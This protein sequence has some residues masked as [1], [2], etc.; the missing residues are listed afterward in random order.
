MEQVREELLRDDFPYRVVL[1]SDIGCR[2][3][4]QDRAFF[5]ALHEELFAVV[6]DGMGGTD[7]GALASETAICVAEKLFAQRIESGRTEE[8]AAF[9]QNVLFETDDTVYD[10]LGRKD[11]GTTELAVLVQRDQLFWFSVGDSRL[12][13]FRDGDMIQATRDHNYMLR[14]DEQMEKKEIT[15]EFYRSEEERGEALISYMGMGGVTTF[16]LTHTPFE[17]KAGD[18]LLLCTDGLYKALPQEMIRYVLSTNSTLDRKARQL[19][20]QVLVQKEMLLLDNTTF[21]LIEL[22]E[23]GGKN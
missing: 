1:R 7:C 18:I 11:G 8:V 15:E 6:C 14:L 4:Q 5:K 21:V 20:S 9:L 19:M 16:D 23:T 17:L 12:Y 13:I 2:E 22:K 3:E 10:K